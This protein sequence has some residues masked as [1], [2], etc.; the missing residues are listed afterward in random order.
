[1]TDG[2]PRQLPG[3]A[4]CA[5]AR[6][7]GPHQ[8]DCVWST[9]AYEP[10]ENDALLVIREDLSMESYVP[11]PKDAPSSSELPE[12]ARRMALCT[13]LVNDPAALDLVERHF[14]GDK[15]QPN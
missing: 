12:H 1:M 6:A 7:V 4:R 11:H 10:K 15:G 3:C 13:L 9:A 14:F 5:L 2:G 8:A